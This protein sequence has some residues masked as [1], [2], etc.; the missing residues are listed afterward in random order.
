MA[1]LTEPTASPT[2]TKR[3]NSAPVP[4]SPSTSPDSLRLLSLIE[5]LKARI[6]AI[7]N[8]EHLTAEDREALNDAKESL[9]AKKAA[10][11]SAPTVERPKGK[12]LVHYGT[13]AIEEDEE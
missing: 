12:R 11:E 1:L 13:F 2:K 7:E 6:E 3:K 9:A 8:K 5:D 4:S 10:L